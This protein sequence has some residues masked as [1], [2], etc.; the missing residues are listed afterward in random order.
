MQY[1]KHSASTCLSSIF[2]APLMCS[3]N[4]CTISISCNTAYLFKSSICL[5]VSCLSFAD[6]TRAYITA[7]FSFVFILFFELVDNR[8][9]RVQTT[10][11]DL[12]EHNFL[13]ITFLCVTLLVPAY[14]AII[15]MLSPHFFFRCTF[16]FL[17]TPMSYR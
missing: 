14:S 10:F 8:K 15:P 12:F 1:S 3:W 4:T 11:S 5:V 6:E 9:K 13:L 7:L 2:F 17:N 16:A